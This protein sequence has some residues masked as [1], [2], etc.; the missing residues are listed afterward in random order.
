MRAWE[1]APERIAHFLTK[2]VF[3]LFAEDVGLLPA[4]VTADAASS[5]RSSSRPASSRPISATTP[6]SCSA[7]MADGGSVLLRAIPYFDGRLFDDVHVEELSSEALAALEKACHLDWSAVEPA[8]FGTLFER[9]LDPS[10]RAQLGAHYTSRDD[11]LLIVEPVLM[12]PAPPRM[13]RHPGGS[14]PAARPVRRRAPPS[15]CAST[16]AATS[17][18]CASRCWPACAR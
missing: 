15:A 11:I 1:A 13:G 18:P 8:I 5:P 7:A 17:K 3:C 10:K 12:A 9:S 4:T 2:L 6:M 14:R 16:A